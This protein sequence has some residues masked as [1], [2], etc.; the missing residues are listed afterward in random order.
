MDDFNSDNEVRPVIPKK[1]RAGL[2]SIKAMQQ[3][4][5]EDRIHSKERFLSL[6]LIAK[7]PK[8]QRLIDIWE[9]RFDVYREMANPE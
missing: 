5:K 1:R 8:T 2:E 7:S 6:G 9:N 4:I 3:T